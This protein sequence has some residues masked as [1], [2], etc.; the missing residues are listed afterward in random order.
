MRSGRYKDVVREVVNWNWEF[1][2]SFFGKPLL[3]LVDV[4]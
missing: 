3:E 2:E 1:W 4:F